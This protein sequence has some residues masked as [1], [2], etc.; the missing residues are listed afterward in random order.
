V[1]IVVK[2]NCGKL[3]RP[4]SG[5]RTAAE[6]RSRHV[7]PAWTKA[8]QDVS[9]AKTDQQLEKRLNNATAQPR[10]YCCSNEFASHQ[11]VKTV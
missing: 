9:S 3:S 1:T 2:G 4:L 5:S 8:N 10:C 11:I 6:D 7:R